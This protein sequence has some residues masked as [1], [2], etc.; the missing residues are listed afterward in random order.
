MRGNLS[1]TTV[2]C[3]WLR[4]IPACAGEPLNA[5]AT[6]AAAA[7][8][9]RV[10]GGTVPQPGMQL[11][12]PGL[13]PRVRGNP[14]GTGKAAAYQGSIPACAGEPVIQQTQ[15]LGVGVYPRVCG[16]TPVTTP[17]AA[18]A[19]GL[20]PRVRG[21]PASMSRLKAIT[22]SIPACAG[23][24]SSPTPARRG[25]KVYPRVCGGTAICKKEIYDDEGLSPRVRGNRDHPHNATPAAGS[26]PACA[27]E[28]FPPAS[29]RA[30]PG[31]Y[32]RVCGGTREVKMPDTPIDG[33]SPRVRGNHT[34]PQADAECKGSIPACAGEPYRTGG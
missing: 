32:P 33:L 30:K 20:S 13:S 8:Y 34:C 27:G 18:D 15:H 12:Y 7:V 23:E 3:R 5:A 10:C 25:Q 28:P 11:L 21:N 1:S 29:G 26:I 19:R 2:R 6:A 9:P 22:R 24:P 4:S 14:L 17:S 31:V 16:G